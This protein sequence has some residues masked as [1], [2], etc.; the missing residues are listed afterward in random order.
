ML[1]YLLMQLIVVDALQRHHIVNNTYV[2]MNLCL[3]HPN[4]EL[5]IMFILMILNVIHGQ[6]KVYVVRSLDTILLCVLKV[7]MFAQVIL[8]LMT[9]V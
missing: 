1:N 2:L 3:Y 4:K 5:A 9:G 8:I 6:H 7:V